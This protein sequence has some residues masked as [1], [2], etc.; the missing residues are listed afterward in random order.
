MSYLTPTSGTSDQQGHFRDGCSGPRLLRSVGGLSAHG[1]CVVRASRKPR[2]EDGEFPVGE[3]SVCSA[4][5]VRLVE[6]RIALPPG[7]RTPRQKTR[8]GRR[9][10][11]PVNRRLASAERPQARFHDLGPDDHD[12]L[13]P[14]RRKRQVIRELERLSGKKV[15]LEE[16]A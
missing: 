14:A 7:R 10:Q 3:E 8:P 13:A 12:R 6:H 5:E 11:L 2:G 16:A 15:T 4:I 1:E 9:R